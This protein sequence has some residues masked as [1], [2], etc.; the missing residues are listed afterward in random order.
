MERE[1][2]PEHERLSRTAKEVTNLEAGF[3][4]Y[5]VFNLRSRP[6]PVNPTHL[7]CVDTHLRCSGG[8]KCVCRVPL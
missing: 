7:C 4:F 6:K 3:W 8:V 2:V 5:Y 1:W